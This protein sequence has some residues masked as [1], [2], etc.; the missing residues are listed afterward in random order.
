[1]TVPEF[2]PLAA[3]RALTDAGVDFVVIGGIAGRLHGSVTVTNDLDICYDRSPANL[4]RLSTVLVA[5]GARLRGVE[6]PMPFTPDA[7]TL[8]AGAAFTLVTA[9]GNLD[10]LGSP[11]V[12]PGFASLAAGAVSYDLDGITVRAASLEDL[13]SMKLAAGRPKDLIEA[14]VLGALRDEIDERP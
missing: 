10:I 2:D 4:D 8:A 3:L 6:E 14:E 1:V 11:P 13:I 7:E 9:F 5:A 12:V